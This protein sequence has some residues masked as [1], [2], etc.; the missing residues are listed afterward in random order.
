MKQIKFNYSIDDKVTLV[1]E[2]S[3]KNRA[4]YLNCNYNF[5]PKEYTINAIK[6]ICNE[7]GEEILYQLHAY[8]DEYLAYHNW[9]KE[10]C[11]SGKGT[12]HIEDIEFVSVDGKQL[13]I[14]DCV[15]NGIFYGCL[16]DKYISPDF[17]F[18]SYGKIKNLTCKWEGTHYIDG[19]TKIVCSSRCQ[20]YPIKYW[21][22]NESDTFDLNPSFALKEVNDTFVENY[23]KACKEN[24]INPFNLNEESKIF[25][26]LNFMGIYE[27][28]KNNY[29][30]ITI[31]KNKKKEKD[32]T[33]DNFL[34]SLTKAQK[35]ELLNKLSKLQ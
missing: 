20:V 26:W 14:G 19:K 31:R 11:F 32:T 18:T 17:T 16:D 22:K 2:P 4:S 10:E 9:M 13:N 27:K 25:E 5:S 30:K 1:K 3:Y 15:Y 23:I 34:S 33:V 7:D 6:Y 29:K 28:V 21:M 35:K 12:E 24:R 8:C